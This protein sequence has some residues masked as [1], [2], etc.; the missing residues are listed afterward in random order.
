MRGIDNG[1]AVVI[2]SFNRP[3]L[4]RKALESIYAQTVSPAQILLIID[5]PEDVEKYG[6]LDSFDSRLQ[7]SYTGGGFGGARARNVGLGQVDDANYVFFLDDDDTWLPEKAEKQIAFLETNPECVGCTC[8]NYRVSD[9]DSRLVKRET[10]R[11]INS[12]LGF[13]NTVGSF[14]FFG[15][16]WD[17][18]TREI[19]LW[20][21][22]HASQDWEFYL[23]LVGHGK[24]GVVES[25]LVNYAAHDGPKI[26][27]RP[28]VK[29]EALRMVYNRHKAALTWREKCLQLARIQMIQAEAGSGML[30]R[31]FSSLTACVLALLGMSNPYTK[32]IVTRAVFSN[33]R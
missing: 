3:E 12:N 20:D 24:I 2:P 28:G 32:M 31:L 27:G 13:W 5:E 19:R 21:E 33:F 17:S 23:R 26:S 7:A 10:M 11:S 4:L 6:F 25:P 8:W 18:M 22:L 14:S 9:T 1:Y 16:R 29:A 15:C 30:S